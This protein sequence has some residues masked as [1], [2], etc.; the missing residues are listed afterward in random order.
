MYPRLSCLS[1]GG[2][3]FDVV[4]LLLSLLE[5]FSVT[6][7]GKDV[8]IVSDVIVVDVEDITDEEE[9]VVVVVFGGGG[10]G[11]VV[12]VVDIDLSIDGVF[13]VA[14]VALSFLYVSSIIAA[15]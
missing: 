1:T 14:A 12:S 2:E 6:R 8:L 15:T 7:G 13:E 10:G 3:E 11:D 5:L 4:V 9:V